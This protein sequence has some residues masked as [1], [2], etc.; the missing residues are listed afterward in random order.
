MILLF[1]IAVA[2]VMLY[3]LINR[4][5]T[6]LSEV[7]YDTFERR[8]SLEYLKFD[9]I[10]S[11]DPAEPLKGMGVMVVNKHT[12][13]SAV[14]VTGYNF[15]KASYDTQVNT[16]NSYISLIDTLESPVSMRQTVKKI[17]INYNIGEHKKQIDRIQKE[18]EDITVRIQILIDDA[19]DYLD[20]NPELA[21]QYMDQ[22]ESLRGVVDRK[23]RQLEE[24]EE[25]V[26]YMT[27]ISTDS[28]DTQKVQHILFSYNYDASKF[29]T[30]LTEEEI[31]QEAFNEL[32]SMASNLISQIYRFGGSARVESAEGLV[33]LNYRHMHPA[34]ADE[35]P[36]KELLNSSMD[37]LFVTSNSIFEALKEK[38]GM[39]EL[40]RRLAE[41]EMRNAEEAKRRMLMNERA[42]M[43]RMEAAGK[44]AYAQAMSEL[45]Q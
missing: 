7:N 36:L 3:V 12:F 13:V 20:E 41:A 44:A 33:D 28:G 19:E 32:S 40:K 21:D 1:S 42:E 16:I 15:F 17:D 29:T 30:Q 26:N 23:K 43:D 27:A 22:A 39:D 45:Q 10:I 14:C 38:F 37:A 5:K 31:Y 8:D 2:A 6:S 18:I 35:V 25:M 9:S 24:A 11:S 34:T 4:K